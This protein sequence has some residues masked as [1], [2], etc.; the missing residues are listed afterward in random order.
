MNNKDVFITPVWG[1]LEKQ[2]DPFLVQPKGC[3]CSLM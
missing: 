2:D 1:E 3:G